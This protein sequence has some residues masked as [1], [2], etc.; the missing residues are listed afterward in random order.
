MQI[1]HF[2]TCGLGTLKS[3]DLTYFEMFRLGNSTMRG[4]GTLKYVWTRHFEI[5]WTRRCLPAVFG[6]VSDPRS[7]RLP[8]R[9]SPWLLGYGGGLI[10]GRTGLRTL[11]PGRAEPFCSSVFT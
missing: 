1:R 10:W 3:G 4:L 5:T 2:E 9:D 8:K 7:V 11:S 6:E